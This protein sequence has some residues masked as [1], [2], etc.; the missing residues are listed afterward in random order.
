MTTNKLHAERLRG[1]MWGLLVGDA[2]GVPYEFHSPVEL[3]PIE[4]IEM[5]PPSGFARAHVGTPPGTWSDDGA[6]AL[7]L[8][9][10]LLHCDGLDLDD[11]MRRLVNWY[12]HGYLAVDGRVFDVGIQ[13]GRAIRAFQ[14]GTPA[15][16]AGP[17]M[18][19]DNGNGALMR[20]APLALWHRGTDLDLV[21]AAALQSR[22]THGHPRSQVCCALYCLWLRHTVREQSDPWRAA[23]SSLRHCLPL[24][25]NERSE[26]EHHI[27]PDEEPQGTGSGYVVDCLK[28]A[29]W[30]ATQGNFESAV[31]AAISL[32]RDTDTTA[33]VTGG[34]VGARDGEAAIPPR[35]LSMLR[36]RDQ[37]AVL[38]DKLQLGA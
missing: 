9:A 2:L 12:E 25:S 36:D 19:R 28:S 20:V 31:K 14:E 10:S 6:H 13:T 22:I 11:L 38:I 37:A 35:W 16:N 7:C 17:A 4:Q 32:G 21:E 33:C 3:P 30:A 29:R 26:L 27:R 5:E 1:A 18:E 8:L 34:L 24:G 15:I 23:V